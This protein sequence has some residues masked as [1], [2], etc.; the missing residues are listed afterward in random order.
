[1]KKVNQI[2]DGMDLLSTWEM[3]TNTERKDTLS[4]IIDTL[5]GYPK[6]RKSKQDP[7]PHPKILGAYLCLSVVR[8][9]CKLALLDVWDMEYSYI[10]IATNLENALSLLTD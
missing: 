6:P 7:E 10:I 3:Q 9:A 8:N 1:M 4:A 5:G 2:T